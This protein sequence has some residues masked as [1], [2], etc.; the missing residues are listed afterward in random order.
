MKLLRSMLWGMLCIASACHTNQHDEETR[1]HLYWW[2]NYLQF[3]NNTKET[4]H[5]YKQVVSL[6]G[7]LYCYEGLVH[8]LFSQKQFETIVSLIPKLD[9]LFEKKVDMQKY[10]AVA[11]YF[12]GKETAAMDRLVKLN[13]QVPQ[14]A[15]IAHITAQ[16]LIHNKELEQALS[17]LDSALQGT[18]RRPT[19]FMFYYLKAQVYVS[20]SKHEEAIENLKQCVGL[21]SRFDKGWL[22]L[23]LLQ[24]QIGNIEEAMHGYTLFLHL[25]PEKNKQIQDHVAG[26]ALHK[27]LYAQRTPQTKQSCYQKALTLRDTHQYSAAASLLQSCAHADH[28]QDENSLLLI[29]ILIAQKK[30]AQALTI[31]GKKIAMDPTSDSWLSIM[32]ALI[33]TQIPLES[34]YSAY[35]SLEQLCKKS[36]WFYI[37]CADLCIRLDNLEQALSHLDNALSLTKEPDLQAKLLTQQGVIYF[38]QRNFTQLA[39]T[40]ERALK[41]AP[42]YSPALNLMA[43]YLAGKGKNPEKAAHY[44]NQALQSDQNNIHFIDTKAYVL[45]KQK[46][47]LQ[48][49][50]LLHPLLEKGID[51]A[52]ILIHYAKIEMALGNTDDAKSIM[53]QARAAARH[54]HE[55]KTIETLS[56]IWTQEFVT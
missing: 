50:E 17:V 21:Q 4:A 7:S 1:L 45:F 19:D 15:D 12:T 56:E 34:L 49:K 31:I 6:P 2:A 53:R 25:S 48:A 35:I 10:F 29:D 55:H 43:Y 27:K 39:S 44:I 20:L 13:K 46:K 3:S 9:E 22:L 33:Y 5:W 30:Y 52:T 40:L 42:A 14:N 26:L 16:I 32:H 54:Q 38:E 11:L 18:I 8:F 36:V 23:A 51:D 24:E 28:N 47:Y 37:Y 41:H